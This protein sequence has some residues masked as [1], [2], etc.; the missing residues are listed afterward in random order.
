M[1]VLVVE[2]D[3][4]INGLL[5]NILDK[6]SYSVRSAFSGTEALM[7]IDQDEYDI[8]LLDKQDKRKENDAYNSYISEGRPRR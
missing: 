3:S 6:R 4:D 2:D 1:K 8:V 7:C 5:C